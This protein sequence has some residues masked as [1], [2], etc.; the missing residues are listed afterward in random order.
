MKKY[1][2]CR[3][4]ATNVLVK[5]HGK[6][7]RIEFEPDVLGPGFR[8]C[9]AIVEDEEVQRIIEHLPC[10]R[11]GQLNSITLYGESFDPLP[12]VEEPKKAP[13]PAAPKKEEPKV[14]EPKIEEPKVEEVKAEEPKV[15]VVEAA[16][17]EAAPV[18]F[19]KVRKSKKEE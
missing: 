16:A 6:V 3:L 17:E 5:A 18:T 2:V 1:Y 7:R 11:N 15:E 9:S 19:K 12:K 4:S 10:F 14:E 13:K 8:G